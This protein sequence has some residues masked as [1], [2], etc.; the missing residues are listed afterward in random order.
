[1]GYLSTFLAF[2]IVFVLAAL[3]GH[4]VGN[5]GMIW[6]TG[7]FG[8]VRPSILDF[9]PGTFG[10]VAGGLETFVRFWRWGPGNGDFYGKVGR[11]SGRR[12]FMSLSLSGEGFTSLLGGMPGLSGR[13]YICI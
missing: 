2:G 1:M 10:C 13:R 5:G 6:T 7:W 12:I 8:D 4:A 11:L 9:R 3:L